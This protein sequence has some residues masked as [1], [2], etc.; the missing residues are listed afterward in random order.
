MCMCIYIFIGP[1]VYQCGEHWSR[2]PSSLVRGAKEKLSIPDD[3]KFTPTK[4][5]TP[6]PHHSSSRPATAH[7]AT[8]IGGL[9]D[10]VRKI[11]YA[12]FCTQD[13]VSKIL[14]ARF[15]YHG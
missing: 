3:D 13:S 12:R 7:T 8:P 11:L 2:G 5:L 10:S 15:D 1:P 6:P 14:L 9:Q 4:H